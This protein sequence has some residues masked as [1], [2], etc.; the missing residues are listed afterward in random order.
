M[1]EFCLKHGEG[2]RWYLEASNY[3]EDLLNDL[4]RQKFIKHFFTALKDDAASFQK[5]LA[6]F[7]QAPDMVK[8]AFRWK[9]V[10]RMKKI[11]YGQIV[12]I[13]D[14]ETIFG[15]VN[16]IIR[17]SCLCRSITTGKEKRYCYGIS[18]GPGGGAFRKVVDGLDLSFVSGPNAMGMEALSKEEA[19]AQF[20]EYEK[21]GLCHSVW[22]F[23]TPFIGGI[24]N[25]DRPDCLAMQ[26]TVTHGLPMMFRAEYVAQ[27]RP[28]SCTGCRRC[29]QVCQFGALGYSAGEKR[30]DID[31]RKCYGCGICRAVCGSEAIYLVDRVKVPAA[32]HIW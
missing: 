4:S 10:R 17:V 9:T 27:I 5:Q 3:S 26:L 1:C 31:P 12:P 7:D 21:E 32:A 15:F 8:R 30:V 16:S 19:L 2:R 6:A 28:E 25:C 24:C 23:Q 29:M 11:H 20:R 13:E 18:M 22:T 14:I